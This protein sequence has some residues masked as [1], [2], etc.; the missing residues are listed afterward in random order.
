MPPRACADPVATVVRGAER[1][2]SERLLEDL[3]L[4]WRSS[5][6]F[7]AS[8]LAVTQLA[9]PRARLRAVRLGRAEFAVLDAASY[10]AL[11]PE[12]PDTVVLSALIAL[13]VHM[14]RRGGDSGT[15]RNIPATIGYT[16]HA[17]FVA[18]ALASHAAAAPAAATSPAL[19]LLRAVDPPGAIDLL[20][21]APPPDTLVLLAAPIGTQ[22][23]AAALRGDSGLR[24]VALSGELLEAVRRERPWVSTVTIAQGTYPNQSAGVETPV[25]RLLLITVPRLPQDEARRMLDCLYGRREQVAPFDALFASMERSVNGDVARWAPYHAT[26]AKEFGLKP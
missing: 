17:R 26:A 2:G 4:L 18:E 16:G 14:L 19:P 23:L 11:R 8:W 15:V 12:Y 10:A 21:Q 25:A 5:Y 9:A 6:A 13:P 22:E 3:A 20:R 24:L 1:D 7:D